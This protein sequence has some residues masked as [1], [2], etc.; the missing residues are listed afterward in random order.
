MKLEYLVSFKEFGV[1]FARNC[2]TA[3]RDY[4]VCYKL[5]IIFK[6]FSY[7]LDSWETK[8]EIPMNKNILINSNRHFSVLNNL[9]I[10][11]KEQ[12]NTQVANF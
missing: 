4:A 12:I 7:L 5:A 1:F 6:G 11:R 3:A 2:V 9:L 10:L 8:T